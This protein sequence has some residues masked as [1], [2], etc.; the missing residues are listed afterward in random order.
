MCPR[1]LHTAS[2]SRAATAR[3]SGRTGGASAASGQSRLPVR[4]SAWGPPSS[5]PAWF[6]N[7]ASVQLAVFGLGVRP[8]EVTR[9]RFAYHRRPGHGVAVIVDGACTGVDEL[10]LCVVVK[11]K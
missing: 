6:G 3:G 7:H 2:H 5:P 4:D 8:P 11:E 9:H 10:I 1:P